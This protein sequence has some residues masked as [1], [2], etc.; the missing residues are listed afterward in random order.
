MKLSCWRLASHSN[1]DTEFHVF[2]Q[3]EMALKEASCQLLP[4]HCFPS[5]PGMGKD[6]TPIFLLTAA[7]AIYS[8]K[9]CPLSG[10]AA[11]ISCCFS[12][13]FPLRP[14]YEKQ[15]MLA[16]L[17]CLQTQTTALNTIG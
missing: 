4:F 5:F 9:E 2:L 17:L 8:I 7:V 12:T 11:S 6:A 1:V 3:W 14:L 16:P 15:C 13:E 10:I